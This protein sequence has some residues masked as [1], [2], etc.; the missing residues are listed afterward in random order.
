VRSAGYPAFATLSPR[1]GLDFALTFLRL[2]RLPW[3]TP[4]QAG[5][6]VRFYDEASPICR[7]CRPAAWRWPDPGRRLR[8][9]PTLRRW[10]GPNRAARTVRRSGS[11]ARDRVGLR[12]SGRPRCAWLPGPRAWLTAPRVWSLG[13]RR[14]P[15]TTTPAPLPPLGP[16]AAR[17][18]GWAAGG[19]P[20]RWSE[21]RWVPGGQRRGAVAR[22]FGI[23]PSLTVNVMCLYRIISAA[24]TFSLVRPNVRHAP[25]S[26]QPFPARPRCQIRG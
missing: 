9:E 19:M 14:W 11:Q 23:R 4:E 20:R 7:R 17:R 12:A 24:S 26:P 18:P 15:G 25:A 16:P 5:T 3:F 21:R 2:T 6:W 22:S 13:R 1:Q 8:D 10:P